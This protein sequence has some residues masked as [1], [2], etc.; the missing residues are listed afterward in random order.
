MTEQVTQQEKNYKRNLV[1]FTL[2]NV[3][4]Q[5]GATF[6][7]PQ[8]A[9]IYF[10]K[11]LNATNLIIGSI[12]PIFL[13][14]HSFPS[15]FWGAVLQNDKNIRLK[16]LFYCALIF[17]P[18]FVIFLLLSNFN[19]YNSIFIYIL[20][21]LFMFSNIGASIESLAYQNY[22][23]NAVPPN[24]RGTLWGIVFSF[25]YLVSLIAFPIMN[26]LNKNLNTY[27]YY[28][29]SFLIYSLFAF[30]A[31]LFFFLTKGPKPV[32]SK[33]KKSKVNFKNY[34]KNSVAILKNDRNFRNLLLIMYLNS[35]I[36]VISSFMMIYIIK[37][38]NISNSQN[39]QFSIIFALLSGVGVFVAGKTGDKLGF[40]KVLLISNMVN[41]LAVILLLINNSFQL[42]YL[43]FPLIVF[44]LALQEQAVINLPIECC[45]DDNKVQYIGIFN[46]LTSPSLFL[47]IILGLLID[48]KFLNLGTVLGMSA[49][50]VL[51]SFFLFLTI[52]KEPRK[53]S[54]KPNT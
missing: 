32:A 8:T 6:V 43:I 50:F 48:S 47:P 51:L 46:T 21:G 37:Q 2:V 34:L 29:Y 18:Y 52:F 27:N 16:L 23:A 49:A 14:F 41:S 7:I 5:M 1:G 25:G 44:S 45:P 35:F 38:F 54:V 31:S 53:N 10:L 26:T 30:V 28:K 36:T 12:V 39:I 42:V 13:F 9:L 17:F 40:K 22:V 33:E 4:W 24:K 11:E 20:L 15:M 3:F 19:I